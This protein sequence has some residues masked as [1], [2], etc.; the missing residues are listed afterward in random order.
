MY[1]AE[2]HKR[3]P[4]ANQHVVKRCNPYMDR[5]DQMTKLHCRRVSLHIYQ[6]RLCHELIG[7]YRHHALRQCR[8]SPDDTQLINVGDIVQHPVERPARATSKQLCV[9][10]TLKYKKAKRQHPDVKYLYLPKRS[11]TAFWCSSCEVLFHAC[12]DPNNC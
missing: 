3:N 9:V 8:S 7:G 5:T 2:E 4:I 11:N 12:T 1:S 6:D 10:C